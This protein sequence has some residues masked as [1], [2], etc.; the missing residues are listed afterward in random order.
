LIAEILQKTRDQAV[1][2]ASWAIYSAGGEDW[3]EKMITGA[4]ALGA[5]CLIVIV[6]CLTYMAFHP[7]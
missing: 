1:D 2:F 5:F 7:K 6:L 4:V 3:Y